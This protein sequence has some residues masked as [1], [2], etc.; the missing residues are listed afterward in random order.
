[1]KNRIFNLAIQL[2]IAGVF[3]QVIAQTYSYND[4]LVIINT[5]SDIS[6]SVGKYFANAR[7]IPEQNIVCITAPT[8][9]EIDSVQFEN[10]RQQIESALISRNLKD[11]INY[12]VTTKGIPLKV[13]R[14]TPYSNSSFENELTLILGPYAYWIG[15]AGKVFSTYYK[16]HENFTRSKFG[17]Y[18]VTRLDGY[19]FHDIKG[20]IDRASIIPNSISSTA[21]FVLDMDPMWTSTPE[22]NGNMQLATDSLRSRGITSYLDTTTTFVTEQTNVLGYVSFGSNDNFDHLYATNAI[23]RNTYL[24]GAI[25]ET[26]VSTSA[27]SFALPETYGQSLIADLIAEGVTAVKG[28]AYEPYSNSMADVSTLFPMY[29]DGYTIGESFYSASRFLSWM[30]VV[31]G[32]PKFRLVSTRIS[33]DTAVYRPGDI[34]SLPVEMVSFTACVEGVN[35]RLY[36]KTAT[37]TN[38]YGFEIERRE[39]SNQQSTTVNWK[40]IGFIA[41]AATSTSPREYTFTDRN[42]AAGKYAFRVKQ[43]DNSGTFTY[44]FSTEIEVGKEVGMPKVLKLTGNYPNP[45]NPT[46]KIQFTV[47]ENGNVRLRIYNVIGQE[48]ADLFNG[49]AVAGNLYEP[50]FQASGMPSGMYV[51]VL[52]FGSQ[53]L[54]SKMMLV[55]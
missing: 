23:P 11:S 41:G 50:E 20:L 45:F 53:R 9:E 35:A 10:I 44:S 37:E 18:I 2:I 52:E 14:K 42:L 43:I 36:W 8:N 4:V 46:T 31:I 28:Y 38:N 22:L 34:T 51:S 25:A 7:K 13:V 24:P 29:V 55:K 32:D 49:T 17:F 5:N 39:V 1:M 30:D 47:P 40:K 33:A 21:Q 12:I 6:D 26:Y 48:V 27:R 54:T 3:T 16:K 15:R 19:T